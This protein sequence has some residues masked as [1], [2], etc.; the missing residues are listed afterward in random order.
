MRGIALVFIG[1]AVAA[2]LFGCATPPE[3]ARTSA[4]KETV[5]LVPAALA[6]EVAE[7]VDLAARGEEAPALGVLAG[8]HAQQLERLRQLLRRPLESPAYWSW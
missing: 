3:S 1:L 4:A 5:Q 6:L 2:V 8:L 7:A